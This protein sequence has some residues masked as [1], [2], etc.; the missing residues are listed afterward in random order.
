MT[1]SVLDRVKR[2]RASIQ[3]CGYSFYG[4]DEISVCA[5]DETAT[6]RVY[7]G[8]LEAKMGALAAIEKA[9]FVITEI[10]ISELAATVRFQDSPPPPPR[11]EAVYAPIKRAKMD[12]VIH[13]VSPR[14]ENKAIC[15]TGLPGTYSYS[16][17][18]VDCAV[19][20]AEVRSGFING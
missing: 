5:D 20:L 16:E 18:D 15:G 17:Q 9:G 1:E 3:L 6:V 7:G 14:N 8:Y 4:D 11:Y 19:C 2:I 10:D 12:G 13:Y